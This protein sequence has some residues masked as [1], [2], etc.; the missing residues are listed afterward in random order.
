MSELGKI[1]EGRAK[2]MSFYQSPRK[3]ETGLSSDRLPWEFTP[4]EIRSSVDKAGSHEALAG[5]SSQSDSP[6]LQLRVKIPAKCTIS[7]SKTAQTQT[8]VLFLRVKSR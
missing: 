4:A 8:P 3:A 6:R 7:A 2:D 5:A 1:K